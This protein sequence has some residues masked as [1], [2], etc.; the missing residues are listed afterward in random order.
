[1]IL[2]HVYTS[3]ITVYLVYYFESRYVQMY[4]LLGLN[5][6]YIGSY[7]WCVSYDIIWNFC[8]SNQITKELCKHSIRA[9]LNYL[10]WSLLTMVT[11][12]VHW[13]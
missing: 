13:M 3:L 12:I 7:F 5:F 2:I 6:P 4:L 11:F 1:M 9:T 8:I 10:I